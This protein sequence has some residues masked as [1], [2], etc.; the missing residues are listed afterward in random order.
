MEHVT[1]VDLHLRDG[2]W[3]YSA[4]SSDGSSRSGTVGYL[5]YASEREVTN[6]LADLFPDALIVIT[7]NG[8][9]GAGA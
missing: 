2:E 3:C 8:R 5:G 7:G 6:K 9:K 1:I 4:S